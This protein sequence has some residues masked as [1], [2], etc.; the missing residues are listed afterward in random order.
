LELSCAFRKL[1]PLLSECKVW[2]SVQ[3]QMS[4]CAAQPDVAHELRARK[5]DARTSRKLVG[6]EETLDKLDKRDALG[7]TT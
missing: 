4:V 2:L 1:L 3:A 7:N 6:R 5:D